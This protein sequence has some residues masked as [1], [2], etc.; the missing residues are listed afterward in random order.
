MF[1]QKNRLMLLLAAA[2]A[3][4]SALIYGLAQVFHVIGGSEGHGHG[5]MASHVPTAGWISSSIL[6]LAILP[7]VTLAAAI[8]TFIANRNHQ[9]LPW[10]NTLTLTL[11][12]IA[13]ISGSGGGVEFH[14]SIFMVIAALAYYENVKLITLMTVLFAIQH[15]VG[16]FWFPQIIFGTNSYPVL[17]LTI[18]A[19]FLLLTSGATILQIRS[20]HRITQT[21]EQDKAAKEER[22]VDLISRVRELSTSI[23]LTTDIVAEKSQMHIAANAEMRKSFDEVTARLDSQHHS[24][25]MA[26][27]K[28][29]EMGSIVYHG[30]EASDTLKENAEQTEQIMGESD[31][32]VQEIGLK[33]QEIEKAIQALSESM[34][35]TRKSASEA[36]E[37]LAAIE[38]IAD[39]TALLSLNASIEAARAGEH[40]RGFAI[41]A[42]EIRKLAQQSRTVSDEMKLMIADI[43]RETVDNYRNMEQGRDLVKN[44]T[45]HLAQFQGRFVHVQN[46]II[47]TI[48]FVRL[49]N[50]QMV[51][52]SQG[53]AV[54]TDGMKDIMT[55]VH[56]NRLAL[57]QLTAASQSQTESAVRVDE[58]IRQLRG[59][60]Q[61]LE[62]DLN[63]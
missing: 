12:S 43:H 61:N 30:M 42:S 9:M 54:I 44:S 1:D 16:F 52:M 17:M 36:Q 58:E 29:N 59:L 10:L 15:L 22:L 18:H 13:I 26:E 46:H 7:F 40:G 5:D 53:S 14:F 47:Q 11:S 56:H 23:Q 19:L 55:A 51:G 39:Q 25:G 3:A 34:A 2:A 28:L 45:L 50:E 60:T 37:R 38:T 21:L 49:M 4:L 62:Q 32:L 6:L 63:R 27:I 57:E 41:V 48:R 31:L 20:K 8:Y 24:V 35:T 33:Q